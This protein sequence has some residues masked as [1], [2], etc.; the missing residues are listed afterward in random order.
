MYLTLVA[1][2]WLI[3]LLRVYKFH[4]TM[5]F[6]VRNVVVD[7]KTELLFLCQRLGCLA[8]DTIL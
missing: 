4:A 5:S 2:S 1:S 6:V 8:L 7:I 3:I